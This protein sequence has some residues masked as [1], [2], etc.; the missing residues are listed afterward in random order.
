MRHHLLVPYGPHEA[1]DGQYVNFAVLSEAHWELFCKDVIDRPDLLD[2]EEF[3]TN[4]KRVENRETLEPI[5]NE[6]I[7]SESRDVWAER[8]DDAGLPWGDVNEIDEV[9]AH[10]QTD[11]LGM[12]QEI[13]TDDG[14]LAVIDNPIDMSSLEVRREKMPEL[15]E[16][17][18]T[19]LSELGYSR[20]EIESL[21]NA[22]V[23]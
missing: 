3:A 20:S 6:E 14:P 1:A 18:E 23:I 17:S 21:Q 19:I 2:D 5:L 8:L 16:H 12:I 15:G 10:P 9:L 13:E 4:E 11:H 7:A 22:D